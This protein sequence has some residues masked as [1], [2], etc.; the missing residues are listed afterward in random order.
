[1]QKFLYLFISLTQKKLPL[2]PCAIAPLRHCTVAPCHHCTIAPF[3]YGTVFDVLI[4]ILHMK[5]LF[6]VSIFSFMLVIVQ[7]QGNK[8][9]LLQSLE[10]NNQVKQSQQITATLKS[11]SRLF[12]EKDPDLR[13]KSQPRRVWQITSL[14]NL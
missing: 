4:K 8:S 14:P 9:D 5:K 3:I 13:R 2:R 10:S 6:S 11:A 7:A 1:M 12:G